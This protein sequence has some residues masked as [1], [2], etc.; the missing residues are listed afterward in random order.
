MNFI[1]F[2][3]RNEEGS[4]LP[5]SL[6]YVPIGL[7][8]DARFD[9]TWRAVPIPSYLF[10]FH[11]LNTRLRAGAA[12]LKPKQLNMI[13]VPLWD[14]MRSGRFDGRGNLPLNQI[15]TQGIFTCCRLPGGIIQLGMRRRWC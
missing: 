14:S 8:I 4:W 13:A 5:S 2:G 7:T 3:A 15:D 1:Q 11:S 9:S 10:V 12:I 6:G